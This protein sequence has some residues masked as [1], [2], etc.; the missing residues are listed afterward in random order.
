MTND[1]GMNI[2][3]TELN[4]KTQCHQNFIMSPTYS[5]HRKYS[6]SSLGASC[7][8]CG[9]LK[10][11]D[12]NIVFSSSSHLPPGEWLTVLMTLLRLLC[13]W[14]ICAVWL[15]FTVGSISSVLRR[16]KGSCFL[17]VCVCMYVCMCVCVC[18]RAC[19]SEKRNYF[20]WMLSELCWS[21]TFPLTMALVQPPL[22]CVLCLFIAD[23][24][25][26]YTHTH[27][28]IGVLYMC[29]MANNKQRKL[30]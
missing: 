11:A 30:H 29:V 22:L 23:W 24:C 15:K 4:V 28:H 3:H 18:V 12:V 7:R 8:F 10:E 25:T 6:V 17:C 1:F 5:G 2:L 19:S 20:I 9:F 26:L 14:L 21:L 16:Q 13:L 27:T